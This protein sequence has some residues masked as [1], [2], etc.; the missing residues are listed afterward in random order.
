METKINNRTGVDFTKHELIVTE[1]EGLLIHRLK[2]P[3]YTHMNSVKFINTNGIMAV[4]G[5]YGNWMFCREFHPSA[6]GRVSSGY[7]CEKLQIASSQ[8]GYEF[9]SEGTR[10]EIQYGIE[11]GLEEYG[12]TGEEL[13]EA[14]EYY[15][16]L[17]NYVD[18]SEWYYEANAYTE[19]PS[20]FDSEGVPNVKK[21]KIWL[22]IVFDA[23]DEI[24]R[25]MKE[26]NEV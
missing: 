9:D 10:E 21:V 12:Y 15:E 8:N 18:E 2:H 22:Q 24:C 17:L 26:E 3:E 14:K 19:M 1:Q 16:Y 25:R 4:T 20:F 6:E 13:E 5:D 11:K 7:W 23:F